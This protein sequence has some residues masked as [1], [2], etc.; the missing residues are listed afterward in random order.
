METAEG[1]AVMTGTIE[2][3]RCPE[4]KMELLATFSGFTAS[5]DPNLPANSPKREWKHNVRR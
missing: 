2:W 1:G 4:Y 3:M 5:S